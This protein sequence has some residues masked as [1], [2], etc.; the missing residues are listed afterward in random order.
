MLAEVVVQLQLAAVDF[1][2]VGFVAVIASYMYFSFAYPFAL[3]SFMT[4]HYIM[5][6]VEIASAFTGFTIR[7]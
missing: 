6:I 1:V 3:M 2:A 7:L 4:L 5:R